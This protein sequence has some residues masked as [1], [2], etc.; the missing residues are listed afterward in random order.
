[1]C[2]LIH[3]SFTNAGLDH[4]PFFHVMRRWQLTSEKP[5]PNF[6]H[7]IPFLGALSIL[8]LPFLKFIRRIIS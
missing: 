3:G 6:S 2:I 8:L 1:M 7:L 4:L 5:N